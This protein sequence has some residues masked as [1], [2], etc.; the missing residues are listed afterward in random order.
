MKKNLKKLGLIFT[1]ATSLVLATGCGK[2]D[3]KK[4]VEDM[5]DKYSAYCTLGDY[6]GVEY[7]ETKTVITDDVVQ[8]Q[9]D[10]LLDAYATSTE[11]TTGTV[12]DGDTVNIDF[13]GTVDGV[14]FAG[15]ST[16]GG[17][18]ELTLGAGLM[19]PGFEEQIMGHSVGET[20]DIFVTFPEDYGEPTLAGQ[21]AVFAITINTKIE[22]VYPDYTDA[23]V[24]ANTEYKTVAEYEEYIL[25]AITDNAAKSDLNANKQAIMT[26]VIDSAEVNEYPQKDMQKLI[27]DTV[28]QVE[29]QAASSGYELGD[30][31]VGYYGMGSVEEFEEYVGEI[32]KSYMTE[33][34]VVCAVAKAENITITDKDIAEYK[35]IMMEELGITSEESFDEN[36]SAEDLAYYTLAEKVVTY[37]LD[38]A[39]PVQATST[40]AVQ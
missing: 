37:L 11:V 5:V 24:A 30:Y 17:G 28:A 32:V 12:D 3:E 1:I 22:K 18:Y 38:N 6:K 25:T 39:T 16:Q 23:F 9:V 14:E 2:K 29:T 26:L 35:V 15:G 34:I 27:D 4:V 21:D 36:Y 33:K 13:V 31:V 20:F 40:D 8:Y 19:I 10:M 7:V